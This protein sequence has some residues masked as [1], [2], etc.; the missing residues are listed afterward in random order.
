MT[1]KQWELLANNTDTATVRLRVATVSSRLCLTT[2][3]GQYF[4]WM[5]LN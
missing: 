4:T 5:D 1:A 3:G 2:W